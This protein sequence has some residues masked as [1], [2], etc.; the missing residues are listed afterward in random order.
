MGKIKKTKC[1]FRHSA[2]NDLDTK[3]LL[4]IFLEKAGSLARYKQ[5][6][7]HFSLAR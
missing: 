4:Q 1:G 6:A 7:Y 2:K 3:K 5:S